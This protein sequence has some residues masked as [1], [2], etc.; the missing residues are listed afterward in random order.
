MTAQSGGTTV[1][2]TTHYIEEAK[3]ANY[4]S[5]KLTVALVVETF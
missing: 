2:I 4:V 5:F 1:V 3:Q